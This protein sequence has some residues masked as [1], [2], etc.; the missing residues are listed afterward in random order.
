MAGNTNFPQ[1]TK[2]NPIPYAYYS[3]LSDNHKWR[4]AWCVDNNNRIFYVSRDGFNFFEESDNL[5]RFHCPVSFEIYNEMHQAGIWTGGY[6]RM[7]N[8][9]VE[10]METDI[11]FPDG[12]NSSSEESSSSSS[13]ASGNSG[14]SESSSSSSSSS[15]GGSGSRPD[16]DDSSWI[17]NEYMPIDIAAGQALCEIIDEEHDIFLTIRFTW[18][19]GKYSKKTQTCTSEIQVSFVSNRDFGGT[20]RYTSGFLGTAMW[21]TPLMISFNIQYN[22]NRSGNEQIIPVS[23]SCVYP[24]MNYSCS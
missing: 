21:L 14:S 1:G 18:T 4:G 24:T 20:Y 6:V 3:F 16:I 13:E 2:E 5:G 12:F 9:S 23:L 22:C 8:M 17:D 7:D 19:K 10:Y 15:D 11:I